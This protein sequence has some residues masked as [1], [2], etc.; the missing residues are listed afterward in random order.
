MT[1][2][3]PTPC[4]GCGADLA[5][6]QPHSRACNTTTATQGRDH[7]RWSV[8]RDTYVETPKVDAFIAEVI[9]VCQRHGLSI[10]HEDT[11]GAFVIERHSSVN[12]G[13]LRAAMT[14]VEE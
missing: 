14:E 7:G 12:D 3:P 4:R 9:E 1:Y 10:G 11:Q 8:N 6:N 2:V 13:W 5:T